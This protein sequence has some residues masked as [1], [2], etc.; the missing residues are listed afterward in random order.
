MK[1]FP[2]LHLW[3]NSSATLKPHQFLSYVRL[4]MVISLVMFFSA[5]SDR[6]IAQG[7]SQD[8]QNTGT[9]L[10]LHKFVPKIQPEIAT[11]A[12]ANQPLNTNGLSALTVQQ[13]EMLE[14]EKVSRTSSQRK[15][16][17]NVLYTMRMLQG[18]AAA[19]GIPYLNTGV[20]LD[21]N[22]NIVV[23]ITAIVT[24]ELLKQLQ[25]AGATILYTSAQYRAIRAII[26]P[27]QIENIAASVD[28]LFISP[29]V[30]SITVGASLPG[31]NSAPPLLPSATHLFPGFEQRA[32]RV[33]AELASALQNPPVIINTGQG[34]VTTEGDATHRAA[35]ARGTFGVTGSGLKIGVLSDSINSQGGL[36]RSQST[37]DMPP[38]CGIPLVQPCITV[39]QDDFSA[40]SDEGDAMLE[41]IYDMAP[42]ANLY[43]ATADFGEANFASNIQALRAAGCDIIVDDVLYFDEPVFQDGI[44]AQAVSSVVTS[45]ALYFSSAGNSGNF[46]SNTSGY[47]EGDFNDAGSPAFS[48]GKSGTIHNF[49]TAGNPINGDVV[50]APGPAYTLT[51]A[52]PQGMSSNDYD[53]FLVG[54]T[55]IVEASSTNLQTGAQNPF[56]IIQPQ[57]FNPGDHLVV[58]KTNAAAALAFS[59]NTLGGLLTETS[60]GQI[61]GHSAVSA[62]GMF[63]VAATPAAAGI[64]SGFPSGPF[65]N[66]FNSGN[67]VEPFTSDGPRRV[68]FNSDGTAITPGNLLIGTNGGIVRNKPDI[69]AADGVSTTLPSQSGLNPF[70]GTS[71]AAPHAAAIAALIKSAKPSLTPTQIQTTLENTAIDIMSP[72]FDRDSG[73]G[74]A[75]AYQAVASLGIPGTANPELA[76]VTASQNPG[77]GDGVLKAGEGGKL[78][79]QLKNT[80]GVNAATGISAVLT[81]TTPGV[82]VTQPNATSFPDMPAGATG[83]SNQ[84]PLSFTLAS[85]FVPGTPIEF[86]LALTYTGGP[87]KSLN[88]AVPAGIITFT[89]TLG[90]KPAP[91]ANVTTQTGFQTNRLFRTGGASVCA[92]PKSDP[93][94]IAAGSQAFDSYTFT[95]SISTCLN[96]TLTSTNGINMLVAAYSPLFDPTVV[97]GNY[98]GDSGASGSSQ[99]FGINIVAGNSYTIVVSDVRGLGAGTAYTLQL[100]DVFGGTVNQVP[101]AMAHDVTVFAT[102]QGGSANAN[103]NNG[104]FDPDGDTLTIT[105]TPPGPY[106]NGVTNVLLTV[107]DPEGA[108][109]QATA[110][111]TVLN[112]GPYLTVTKSHT[113]NFTQGQNG[114]TY[115][116][117]ASN[118][119]TTSTSGTV[120]IVD[121]LPIGLTATGITGPGWTCVLGTLTCTRADVLPT[122]SSYPAISLTVNV[123]FSAPSEVTNSV[124]VSGGGET[125]PQS[126][127][128][129]LTVIIPAIPDLTIVKSHTGDFTPGQIGATYT[130]AISN[131]GNGPTAGTVTVADSLPTFFTTA[132]FTPTSMSGTG[133]TCTLAIV[134]CTRGDSLPVAGSYPPISLVANLAATNFPVN[135]TNSAS[136]SGGGDRNPLNNFASDF[137]IIDQADLVLQMTVVTNPPF[138]QGETGVVFDIAVLNQGNLPTSAP[139]TLAN[140]LPAGL[141]ATAMTGAGWSCTLAT[142]TCNTNSQLAGGQ[143]SHIALTMNIATN[144][145]SPVFDSATVSGGG[146]SNTANDTNNLVLEVLAPPVFAITKSHIGNFTQGQIGATYAIN[147]KNIGSGPALNA[148]VV[149]VT[150]TLPI[151]L[152][153]TGIF[154]PNGYWNC[155]LATFTCT[156]SDLL[157]PGNS[158]SPITV[159]VN[160]ASNAPSSVT[161]I[162]TVSGGNPTNPANAIAMDPTTITQ[163]PTPPDMTISSTHVG[164]F[165]QGQIGAVY[166]LTATNIGNT[167]TSAAV[168]VTDTLPNGLIATTMT[169]PGW[170]CTLA[171]VSCTRNDALAGNL[172]FPVITL[173]VNVAVTAPSLLTNSV[174][175]SGGGEVNTTNDSAS[176]PTMIVQ[177]PD[178]TI[179]K[180][181]I[182]NFIQGQTGA[183]FTI[184]VSNIGNSATTQP[185]MVSDTLPPGL[186]A[187]SISGAGWVCLVGSLTCTNSSL[188][189]SA[190]SYPAITVTVNVANNAPVSVTNTAT[191]S[192]GGQV[193]LSNDVATDQTNISPA[194]DLNVLKAHAGNFVQG[195]TGATYTITVNNV[196]LGPTSGA[197]SV[198]DNLPA[199]L[200]ATA[201]AGAGW[202]CTLGPLVCTRG[203]VLSASQSYPAITLT[204]NVAGNAPASVTNMA[205]VSGGGELNLSNDTAVDPTSILT[206]ASV[207]L[208]TGTLTFAAQPLNTQSGPMSVTVTNNGGSPLTFSLAPAITGTNFGD[209]GIAPGTTCTVASP[210]PSGGNC[211]VKVTITP[212]AVGSRGPALLTLTDNANPASQTVALNGS[213]ID[214]SESGPTSPVTVPAGTPANFTIGVT[215]ATGGFASLVTFSVSGLP[216]DASASFNPPTLTP[217]G[218]ATSTMLAVSTT[219]RSAIMPPSQ[220][221][222]RIP[223]PVVLL[224]FAVSVILLA[225][226]LLDHSSGRRRRLAPLMFGA[227]VLLTGIGLTGCAK[228][229]VSPPLP[230]GTPAGTYPLTVTA[231]S[232]SDVHT[233]TVTLI[234]Q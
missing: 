154:D 185:A 115:T 183:T 155:T 71:A 224:C 81:T 58:F 187:T 167:S 28:V 70:Y 195:Q 161:N 112:P 11:P 22:N 118:A 105:Q 84:S 191:V 6:L 125:N 90:T 116:I 35:D 36:T 64:G 136:V 142:T 31:R 146:E 145:P 46:D 234:V 74:I 120:S 82:T 26:P 225:L 218:A 95:A 14:I 200:T 49:G 87:S 178:L 181:H 135:V 160:V 201:M 98:V 158:Y 89:N 207:V 41:I 96:V 114:A 233:A 45:G 25:S 52:D 119:G 127:A 77:N 172:A 38:T 156:R 40:G 144:A 85:N 92:F 131:V 109:A 79:I 93:G 91:V 152:T 39:L 139:I 134:T 220:K 124:M 33:R 55:G 21:Q 141:I 86:S 62:P 174:T 210:L 214:F 59:L 171:T 176:D 190:A 15:I 150:D 97:G 162:T 138:T 50:T 206:P 106:P 163:T 177:L 123:S 227:I 212:G 126:T 229:S 5:A 102:T 153:G 20:D 194:P 43:F 68:F 151:G 204:V 57:S 66:P 78:V 51:W 16:D 56:E 23:D 165:T 166:T 1:L 48:T 32:A 99:S 179:T 53:L 230:S 19:P 88:F 63:S 2:V 73:F 83:G 110:N 232:G 180:T 199:G 30:A 47:F 186:T 159:T 216:A 129:D 213:G 203:D 170:S 202:A 111:V 143:I 188:V 29:K 67:T 231:T 140:T 221:V 122:A 121:T 169:G 198:L 164:S 24:D 8:A 54:P 147:I 222:P 189:A 197:V 137:T 27:N 75:M 9:D 192:G 175:V 128:N 3:S 4:A 219:A 157:I 168:T 12:P 94:S 193:N 10:K 208:S 148:A 205:A 72:G 17:S 13:I 226:L 60:P 223:L 69:T 113:A 182:G 173:I 42:G 104:S 107:V 196:G 133:W 132:L 100:T 80:T 108:T 101:T 217:G 149:T 18:Q 228:S 130:I 61:H 209:F 211:L 117:T 184:T 37:G 7:V 215:P 103:I 34:I 65:P 76:V 44:V